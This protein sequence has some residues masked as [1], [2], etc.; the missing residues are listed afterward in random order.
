MIMQIY[1]GDPDQ[2]RH[3]SFDLIFWKSD[4]DISKQSD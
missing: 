1:D 4:R 3:V 2:I